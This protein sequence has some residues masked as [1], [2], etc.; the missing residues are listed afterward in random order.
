MAELSTAEI[1]ERTGGD[2][3]GE[4][5]R[6]IRGVASLDEAGPDDLSFLSAARYL[7]RLRTTRAGAVLLPRGLDAEAPPELTVIRVDDPYV[8]LARILPVLHPETREPAG[9]HPSALVAEDATLGE[10]VGVGPYAV[11]GRGARLGAGVRVGAHAVVGAGCEVGE[12]TVVHPHATLHDGVRVGRRCVVHSGARL[13]ADGFRFVF[14]DGGHRKLPHVG[15]CV[16]GDDV[17]IGANTTV[18]RGSIGDTSI[19]DGTKIDNLVQVGHNVRIGRHVLVVAQVGISGSNSI[20]DYAV[21]GGQ[22]GTNPHVTIGAGAKVAG[23]AAITADVAPGET[24]SGYP[25]R[26]HR[27]AMRAQAALFRL[28][29][30]M[31]R[32]QAIEQAVLGRTR[33]GAG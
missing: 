2:A 19:G 24:V 7:P 8:A 20:G 28:P 1:T 22:A 11:I 31:K 4:C 27:E 14:M 5:G 13:G 3:V 12:E 21:L 6:I 30:L 15:G 33:G 18:D 17:E 25:A 16:L 10:G 26:P 9:V 29:S 23:R 32:I